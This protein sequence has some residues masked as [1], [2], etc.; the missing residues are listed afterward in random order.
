MHIMENFCSCWKRCDDYMFLNNNKTTLILDEVC[1]C[2]ASHVDVWTA[3]AAMGK[4]IRLSGMLR[5]CFKYFN[6]TSKIL[7]LAKS[8]AI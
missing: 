2:D 7:A 3:Y 5:K 4:E 6:T 1:D 8:L